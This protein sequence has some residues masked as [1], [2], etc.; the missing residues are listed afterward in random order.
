[1]VLC[2]LRC[3]VLLV[4]EVVDGQAKTVLVELLVVDVEGAGQAKTVDVVDL[5]LSSGVTAMQVA[6]LILLSL[7]DTEPVKAKTPLED[8]LSRRVTEERDLKF[9]RG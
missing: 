8:A 4:T 9:P 6:A 1:M 5:F 2:Q 7:R 3:G